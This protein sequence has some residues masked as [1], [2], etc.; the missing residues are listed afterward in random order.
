MDYKIKL[1][2]QLEEQLLNEVDK[3]MYVCSKDRIESLRAYYPLG[4]RGW[5]YDCLFM[6]DIN[7]S[8][9][10][11]G[12]TH[13]A[14]A[15][16][17]SKRI[18]EFSSPLAGMRFLYLYIAM[19]RVLGRHV[20]G[21]ANEYHTLTREPDGDEYPNPTK[22]TIRQALQIAKVPQ[23]C[24]S[25]EGEEKPNSVCLKEYGETEYRVEYRN[26]KNK[27]V[28]FRKFSRKSS[29]P[30]ALNRMFYAVFMLY[31][32]DEFSKKI[33]KDGTDFFNIQEEDYESYVIR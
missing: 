7:T 19:S 20:R 28:D 13:G 12:E 11:Y 10:K 1:L 29:L 22:D 32:W 5:D 31:L 30:L 4:I 2:V 14:D 6:S 18:E 15:H 9:I 8:L 21:F 17:N 25:L 26:S 16:V 24:Y 33:K 23:S 3:D 27:L